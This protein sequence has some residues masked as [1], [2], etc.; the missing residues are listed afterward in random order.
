MCYICRGLTDIIHQSLLCYKLEYNGRFSNFELPLLVRNI[1]LQIV[2]FPTFKPPDLMTL[3]L[4]ALPKFLNCSSEKNIGL[5]SMAT[6]GHNG[7]E[8]SGIWE[9]EKP[10][11][12]TIG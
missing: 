2:A 4:C 6:Y 9:T 11:D 8:E 1:R 3:I 7:T 5:K 12:K 10:M